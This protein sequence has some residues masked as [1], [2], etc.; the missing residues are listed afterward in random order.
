[1]DR[2]WTPWRYDYIKGA[3]EAKL[4]DDDICVLCWIRDAR[5][6][7]ERNFVLHRARFNFVVLNIYPYTNGHLMVV[8]DE[9]TADLDAVAKETSDE[10]MDLAKRAQAA[11]RTAYRPHGF[12]FGMNLGQSA[13]A[14]IA[15]HIHLH[16]LP[17][18]SGDANF[19][20]AVAET[21][22]LP[23]DL[24]TTYRKLKALF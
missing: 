15:G 11:L 6:D 1:M 16:A 24:P 4:S 14:G 2:L 10:M 18:W 8:P 7:D 13:G 20:T 5:D 3:A 21:R 22:V 19:M 12:N 23:E 17:R 9:H